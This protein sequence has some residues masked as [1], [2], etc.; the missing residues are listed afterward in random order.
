MREAGVRNL[1]T[2]LIPGAGHFAQEEAPGDVW[3]LIHSFAAATT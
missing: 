3:D 1:T 2:A